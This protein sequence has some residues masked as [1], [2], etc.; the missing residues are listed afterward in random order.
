[1]R[2]PLPP[3]ATVIS[4]IDR[5]NHCDVEGLSRLMTD[6]H[7]LQILDEKPIVGREENVEAWRGYMTAFPRYV[8]YPSRLTVVGDRVAVLG[9]TT[10]SHLGLPDE[11]ELKLSV[12]WRAEVLDG[13]VARWELLEDTPSLRASLGLSE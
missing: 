2:N 8:I 3:L 9:T 13:L 4:F 1:M 11:D 7:T 12:I 6:E 5:I 10:G